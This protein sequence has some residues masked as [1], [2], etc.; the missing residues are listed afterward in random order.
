MTENW[1]A[2]VPERVG[3]G[4]ATAAVPELVTPILLLR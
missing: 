4:K 1:L 3:V 2:S